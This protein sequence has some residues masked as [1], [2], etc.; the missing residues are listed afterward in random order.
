MVRSTSVLVASVIPARSPENIDAAVD[1]SS[2]VAPAVRTGV[3]NATGDPPGDVETVK[4]APAAADVRTK[5]SI[6]LSSTNMSPA[7]TATVD[8]KSLGPIPGPAVRTVAVLVALIVEAADWAVPL[9]STSTIAAVPAMRLD[10]SRPV[11]LV[12][13]AP[14]AAM[15]STEEASA[16]A[17]EVALAVTVAC[18]P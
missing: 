12:M 11:L 1:A 6:P 16:V 15:P 8:W 18:S 10:W 7:V 2:S 17:V 3:A 13:L 4:S 14:A 5:Y 9:T